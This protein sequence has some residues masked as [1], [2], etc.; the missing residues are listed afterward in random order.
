ML[1]LDV[2]LQRGAFDL[3]AQ[4]SL[5]Q[6][7]TGLFGVSGSGKSTLLSLLAGLIHPDQGC[8][9]LGD[10]CLFDSRRQINIAPN[11]REIGVVFQDSQL[12]PHLR[13]MQN[14]VYGY[15][16]RAKKQRRF[17]VAE[18]VDLLEIGHL[19]KKRPTQLSGGEKQRVGLGRALLASPQFLLLDEPLASLDQGLKW[20]IL[21]FLKRVK[22]ELA[23]PMLYIS[24]SMEEILHL[25]DHLVVISQGR[26]LGVGHFDTLIH[27]EAVRGV[28]SAVGLENIIRVHIMRHD[29]ESGATIVTLQN[30]TITLPLAPQFAVGECCY[31][32]VRSSEVAIAKQRIAHISIQNQIRG[33][34]IAWEKKA[35][36]VVL[37]VDIGSLLMVD[38]M[39]KAFTALALQQGEYIYC[40]MKAQS[41]S[42]LGKVS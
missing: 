33:R 21:P 42:F 22:D 40:L 11:Q 29:R 2:Q 37:H 20:Q 16:R 15:Q 39:P 24:H 8:I 26:I 36:C 41:F 17:T 7:V 31:I 3:K 25:T 27:T 34:L 35:S 5:D 4:F 6:A 12:F 14:L 18:I 28:A 10:K 9:Q 38:I 23:L 1:S 13:V 30:N 32:T 19:L